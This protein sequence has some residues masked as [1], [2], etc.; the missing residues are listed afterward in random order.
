M[1]L[2]QVKKKRHYS[3]MEKVHKI[4]VGRWPIVYISNDLSKEILSY[5]TET[6][7][8]HAGLGLWCSM[9]LSTIFQLYCGGQFNWWSGT[10]IPC[11]MNLQTDTQK[12]LL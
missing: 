7:V 12:I 4:L 11:R 10:C 6:K 1:S 8:G 2:L 9:P 3:R 5:Y